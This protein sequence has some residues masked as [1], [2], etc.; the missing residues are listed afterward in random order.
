MISFYTP[1]YFALQ[2]LVPPEI[3]SELGDSAWRFFDPRMLWTLDELRKLFGVA[4]VNNWHKDGA[5]EYSGLRPFVCSTGAPYSLHKFGRAF[6]VKFADKKV[7]EVR[8][9]IWKNLELP[10]FQHITCIEMNVNWLHIDNRNYNKKDL[11][12]LKIYPQ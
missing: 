1:T 12:I 5:N 11:G 3:Y 8:E 7:E 2:E 6:D 9:Y 4:Y 10:A